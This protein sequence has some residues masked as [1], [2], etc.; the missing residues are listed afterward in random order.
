MI[1]EYDFFSSNKVDELVDENG[2]RNFKIDFGNFSSERD[3][4]TK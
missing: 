4:R 2:M 1:V 3:E